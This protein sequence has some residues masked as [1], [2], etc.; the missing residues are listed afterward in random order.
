MRARRRRPSGGGAGGGEDLP[1][2]VTSNARR[3]WI[4]Q[5]SGSSKGRQLPWL[6]PRG[7]TRQ[8]H[9]ISSLVGLVWSGLEPTIGGEGG[10][11]HC[12]QGVGPGPIKKMPQF[13][14]SSFF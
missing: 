1:P 5:K 3:P 4:I 8:P 7:T 2:G 9:E 13:D 14:V 11:G 12:G 6:E 10:S